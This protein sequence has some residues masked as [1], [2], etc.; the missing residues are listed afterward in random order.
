MQA[1]ASPGIGL[2]GYAASRHVS[3]ASF[4]LHWFP[5]GSKFEFEIIS[6]SG[7][8]CTRICIHIYIRYI[9]IHICIYVYMVPPPLTFASAASKYWIGEVRSFENLGFL[10]KHGNKTTNIFQTNARNHEQISKANIVH[11]IGGQHHG[12]HW[13]CECSP[14]FP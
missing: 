14:K 13:F 7:L 12:K 4:V 5:Q 3:Q 10:G 6:T 11:E 1:A 9:G 8:K 2:C